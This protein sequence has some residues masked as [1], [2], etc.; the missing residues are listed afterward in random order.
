MI[1]FKHALAAAVCALFL[2]LASLPVF[3]EPSTLPLVDPDYREAAPR[4][5]LDI[6]SDKDMEGR[7]EFKVRE[8]DLAVKARILDIGGMELKIIRPEGSEGKVLPVIYDCHGGGFL[9]RR[10]YAWYKLRGGKTI[11]KEDLGYF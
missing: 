10:A 5:M 4:L 1:R 9:L 3:S 7:K 8:K 2:Q 11:S 6:R